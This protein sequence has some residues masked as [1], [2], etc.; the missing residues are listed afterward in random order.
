MVSPGFLHD[1]HHVAGGLGYKLVV[2]EL[3]GLS[4]WSGPKWRTAVLGW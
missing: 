4:G 3:G 2:V 1:G